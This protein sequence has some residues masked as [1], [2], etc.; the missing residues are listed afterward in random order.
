MIDL[1][2]VKSLMNEKQIKALDKRIEEGK[3]RTEKDTW[4][5]KEMDK[6]CKVIK[7]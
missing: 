2:I 5:S 1:S 7:K 4:L 3:K 6:L